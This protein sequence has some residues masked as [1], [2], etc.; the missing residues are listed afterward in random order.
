MN[1]YKFYLDG[2]EIQEPKGWDGGS[3]KFIR[4]ERFR[5]LFVEYI[6]NFIL[7][8]DGYQYVLNRINNEG[9]CGEVDVDIYVLEGG[10]YITYFEGIIKMSEVVIN[11]SRC[12]IECNIE[13]R[14]LAGLLIS[15]ADTKVR[16]NTEKTISGQSLSTVEYSC[17]AHKGTNIT[18]SVIHDQSRT[19]YKVFDSFQYLLNYIS[20]NRITLVST[21]FSTE[22]TAL[23]P[24][25]FNGTILFTNP[26]VD[27]VG[28]GNVV[29]NYTNAFGESFTLT[30]PKQGTVAATL[31]YIISQFNF[32]ATG[33]KQQK[34]YAQDWRYLPRVVT[35]GTT[36][37]TITSHIKGF[38]INSITGATASYT[39]ASSTL[40]DE[41]GSISITS[42]SQL[43]GVAELKA[44]LTSDYSDITIDKV[45]N[46]SFGELWDNMNKAMNLGMSL[47]YVSGVLTLRIERFSYFLSSNQNLSLTNVDDIKISASDK[48]SFNSVDVGDGSENIESAGTQ[49]T[50]DKW[51]SSVTCYEKSL[52]LKNSYIIDSAQINEQII[53]KPTSM[54][55]ATRNALSSPDIYEGRVIHNTDT[56]QLNTAID[57]VGGSGSWVITGW[58]YLN[59]IDDN[60]DDIFIIECYDAISNG[61]VRTSYFEHRIYSDTAAS[62]VQ[63]WAYNANIMNYNKI[64]SWFNM[65]TGN[66]RLLNYTLTNLSDQL[67]TKEYEFEYD[68]SCQDI[69]DIFE[70]PTY[71]TRFSPNSDS[72]TGRIGWS[73]DIDISNK[74]RKATLKLIGK[75]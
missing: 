72:T 7:V 69:R 34:F 29:I 51:I 15:L 75:Y 39:I 60:D 1:E 13:D 42:G 3:R 36:T 59:T 5:G 14:T 6:N 45:V 62:Y 73:F 68:L 37:I 16:F 38:T 61:T 17:N 52:N 49:N 25:T 56:N 71:F 22:V 21:L 44:V 33:S 24:P 63:Y 66:V 2:I 54:D 53:L 11:E 12:N 32:N 30:I 28:A 31:N 74:T 27:L 43:R 41:F 23:V 4:N 47:G 20:D 35:N 26:G 58:D 18:T 70:N 40:N 64:D 67:V 50:S 65:I 8:G 19:M 55:T 48:Y 46:T 9:F 57:N 10:N